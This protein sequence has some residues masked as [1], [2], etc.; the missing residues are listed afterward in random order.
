MAISAA[1]ARNASL[2]S[3]TVSGGRFDSQPVAV[4][5]GMAA[6]EFA[7]R[8]LGP[9]GVILLCGFLPKVTARAGARY[10]APHIT[11]TR[12]PSPITHHPSPIAC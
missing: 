1:I 11:F 9:S 12:H 6:G 2:T 4:G 7:G 5:A 10:Y 8:G 3:I